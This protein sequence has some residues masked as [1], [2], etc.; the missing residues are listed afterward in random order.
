MRTKKS[1]E[2]QATDDNST[3]SDINDDYFENYRI[4]SDE[5]KE[6]NVVSAP[7]PSKVP[8]NDKPIEMTVKKSDNTLSEMPGL[9]AVE[10]QEN[11]ESI[12]MSAERSD[13]NESLGTAMKRAKS[14][15]IDS[16]DEEED[17]KTSDT[18]VEAEQMLEKIKSTDDFL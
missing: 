10:R 7:N 5:D 6:I 18:S 9:Y 4:K 13:S 8:K 1:Y 2:L 11:N 12:G 14:S 16:S 3:R 17:V 15:L